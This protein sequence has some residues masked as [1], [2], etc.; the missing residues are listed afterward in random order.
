MTNSS[1]NPSHYLLIDMPLKFLSSDQR[2]PL[3]DE[4]WAIFSKRERRR[5]IQSLIK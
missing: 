3:Q 2:K 4:V 5:F 1:N